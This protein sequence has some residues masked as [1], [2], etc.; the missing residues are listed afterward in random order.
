MMT[1][2]DAVI[3]IPVR[4]AT[5]NA[6]GKGVRRA[7]IACCLGQGFEVF[8]FLIF[9]FFS[10]Q[11]GRAFF[12]HTD[13]VVSLLFAL[14]TF[15]AGFLMRP[16]GAIVFGYLGDHI[17]RRT[18]LAITIALMAIGV[19]L[20]GLVPTYEAIGIAGP[21][22]LVFFRLLQGFSMGGEWGGAAT[23]LAEYAP[24]G[25]RG[26][27][28]SFQSVAGGLGAIAAILVAALLN[29]IL[30][31]ADLQAWGWRLPFIF[32]ALLGPVAYYLRTKVDETPAYE[33]AMAA[34]TKVTR[35][36]LWAAIQTHWRMM[37]VAGGI[38]IIL[39]TLQYM[40]V[41]FMP[42]YATRTL[43][44]DQA[45]ALYAAAVSVL[46]YSALAPVVGNISDRIGRRLPVFLC[47]ALSFIL[48]YPAFLLLTTY[49]TPSTF[50]MVQIGG[51]LLQSLLCGV[52]TATLAEMFPTTV[53]YTALSISSALSNT[54]FGGFAPFIGTYLVRLTGNPLSPSFYIMACALISG[55]AVF[56]VKSTSPV[57]KLE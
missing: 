39:I 57:A 12:P 46:V 44:I 53:R 43:H 22:L 49:P 41:V 4:A 54:V 23:A 47:A 42:S 29:S 6:I 8:D 32:G 2:V 36:P 14:G 10:A 56:F 25:R 27:L 45:S 16:L 31:K 34:T 48:A 50:M 35:V 1:D 9:G 40:F 11:I 17:G 24:P 3:P 52:I 51:G 38:N 28:S 15:G 5:T 30:N 13:P 19:G 26:F 21:I 20:T 33:E 37:L 55:I 18:T 7:I